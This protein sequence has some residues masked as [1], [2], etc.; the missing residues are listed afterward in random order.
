MKKKVF[1]I[2]IVLLSFFM[3]ACGSAN[4][5]CPYSL[6]SGTYGFETATITNI[7]TQET[8]EKS[9]DD[10]L[11]NKDDFKEWGTLFGFQISI[12]EKTEYFRK[13]G[14]AYFVVKDGL[15]FDIIGQDTLRLH[16]SYWRGYDF[17][18]YDVVIL[19]RWK[20]VYG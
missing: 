6:Q 17:N 12:N 14:N 20:Q 5:A 18:C 1:S 4:D 7:L 19:L 16:F 13:N 9:F 8:V 15:A 11:N 10:I 2:L 3:P